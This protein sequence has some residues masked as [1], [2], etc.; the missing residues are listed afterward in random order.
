MA[1]ERRRTV[2]RRDLSRDDH[3]ADISPQL[4][5]LDED[6]FD[7]Y[8]DDD[9][10]QALELMASMAQATDGSLAMLARRLAGRLIL[11]LART[12]RARSPGIGRLASVP[13]GR[14]DGDIDLDASLD[15]LTAAR[16]EHRPPDLDQLKVSAWRRP[17][18]SIC[19]L[20]D[21]S[22]SMDGQRLASAAVA[23]AV[24][25]WRAPVRFAVLAFSDR[26]VAIRELN[27]TKPAEQVVAE[28]LALRGHGTTDVGLALRAAQR[29]FDAAP[30]GRHLTVLLS[31]AEV[32]VGGDPVPS[33]RALDELTLIA[34]ADD[35]SHARTLAGAVGARIAEVTGPLSVLD[36][37]RQVVG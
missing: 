1:E 27:D 15:A 2:A 12:G 19:L 35:P 37:L 32:T 5:Q 3:F 8:L 31:D 21:R 14:S 26:V 17:G 4:G 13:A 16:A 28:V 34:P 18:T 23:A 25:A 6:A 11:D 20:V 24:C 9:P 30:P 29:Q 22:G 33:A 10:D 36:A 7:D